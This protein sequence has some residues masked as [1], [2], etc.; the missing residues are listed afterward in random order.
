MI[1]TTRMMSKQRHRIA[2]VSINRVFGFAITA[3]VSEKSSCLKKV[4]EIP[5]DLKFGSWE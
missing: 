5:V 3:A 1:R 4:S 2:I